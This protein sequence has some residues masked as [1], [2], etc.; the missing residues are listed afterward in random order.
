MPANID[1]IPVWLLFL[2]TVVIVM[3]SIEAGYLLGSFVL[4]RSPGEKES[5]ASAIAGSILG[6]AAFVLAFSFGIVSDRYD[7]RKALVR[8]DANAIG[9]SYRRAD[10][11]AEPDR[12]AARRLFLRYANL[13]LDAAA[14]QGRSDAAHETFIQLL[15]ETEQIQHELWDMAVANARKDMNSHFGALYVDALNR[16][17]DVSAMRVAVGAR[18]RVPVGIWLVLYCITILG[19]IGIGYQTG[20]A[21]SKRSSGRLI[22]ALSFSLV[23]MLIAALDS[24]YSTFIKVPQ[25]PLID[26]RDSMAQSEAD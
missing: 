12:S 4:R 26:L 22:L 23:F 24:P 2:A 20:I 8:E 25:Q 6:L 15:A 11:L 13:R 9:T 1:F 21:G 10:F 18:A 3:L 14:L 17:F 7:S 19:M 16:M 5:P